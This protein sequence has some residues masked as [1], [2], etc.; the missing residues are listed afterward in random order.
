MNTLKYSETHKKI[1]KKM[2]K[3][4]FKELWRKLWRKYYEE[5]EILRIAEYVMSMKRWTLPALTEQQKK[6][7]EWRNLLKDIRDT[8]HR[9]ELEK[10][11]DLSLHEKVKEFAPQSKIKCSR[12]GCKY[13]YRNFYACHNHGFMTCP[14]HNYGHFRGYK[15]CPECSTFFCTKVTKQKDSNF[16]FVCTKKILSQHLKEPK[17]ISDELVFK[18][19]NDKIFPFI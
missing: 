4:L 6:Q 10:L 14:L 2:H 13:S 1:K 17:T 3:E 16:C 7:I 9:K 8:H 12:K 11:Y 18:Y 15:H 5:Q 19:M